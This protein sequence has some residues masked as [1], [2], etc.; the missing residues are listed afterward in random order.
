LLANAL[1][2]ARRSREAGSMF[3]AIERSASDR[4]T[5]QI[6]A[7]GTSIALSF[8]GARD[9]AMARCKQNLR[10]PFLSVA[11]SAA[12]TLLVQAARR[13]RAVELEF[14][15]DALSEMDPSSATVNAARLLS[16][17]CTG[18]GSHAWRISVQSTLLRSGRI[19]GE[20]NQHLRGLICA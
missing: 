10:S 20:V 19:A 18:A 7:A 13:E 15:L 9:E 8:I 3:H 4:L 12:L 6:A 2:A 11:E 17:Y 5:Q 16:N 14:A 1:L